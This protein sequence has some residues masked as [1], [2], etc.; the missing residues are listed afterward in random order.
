MKQCAT[1]NVQWRP[2]Y[3]LAPSIMFTKLCIER[4]TFEQMKE[5]TKKT[6]DYH[7]TEADTVTSRHWRQR[8]SL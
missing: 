8:V 4:V 7:W 1:M 6:D 5:I 3:T 2:K